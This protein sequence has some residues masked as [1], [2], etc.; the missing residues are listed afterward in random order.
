MTFSEKIRN[1]RTVR[2]L[3]QKDLAAAT[4]ITERTI[5]NYETGASLPKKRDTYARLASA[6]GVSADMLMD[7][8]AS[9]VLQASEQ[10]GSRGRR[11]AEEVIRNFRVAAAGGELDDDDLEFIKEAM[12]QTYEDAKKYNARFRNRRFQAGSDSQE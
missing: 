8:N 1:A 9:F 5:Q 6:L 4:G 7:E 2:G 11:Q 10:Y 12:M 3:S